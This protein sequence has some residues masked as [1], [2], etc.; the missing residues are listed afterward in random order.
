MAIPIHG[1]GTIGGV[2]LPLPSAAPAAPSDPGAFKNLLAS[3]MTNVEAVRI[4]A[5]TKV[6]KFLT[7]EG[8]E[9]HD[10]IMSTQRAELS[11]ELFQQVRNK[12][13]QAYNEVMRMQM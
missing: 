2:V 5:D 13:V 1:I 10:V 4:D 3:A 12:V 11:L 7:G 6:Q 8:D 9:L